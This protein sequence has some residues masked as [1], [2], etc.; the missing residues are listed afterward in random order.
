MLVLVVMDVWDHDIHEGVTDFLQVHYQGWR[1]VI[2]QK[3]DDISCCQSIIR[4]PFPD[5]IP[6]R[7]SEAVLVIGKLMFGLLMYRTMM[8]IV[9]YHY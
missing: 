3:L 8:I 9:L 2:W 6:E 7:Q 1:I 4:D 5:T